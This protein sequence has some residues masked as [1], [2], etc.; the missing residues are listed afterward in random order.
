MGSH[1][2]TFHPTQVSTPHLH[3][4][5]SPRPVRPVLDLPTPEGWK[6]ELTCIGLHGCNLTQVR[7][8][9]ESVLCDLRESWMRRM[10][11]VAVVQCVCDRPCLAHNAV[12]CQYDDCLHFLSLDQCLS[13]KVFVASLSPLITAET[14]Q[15]EIK[16]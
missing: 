11:Y 12:R 3:P 8:F 1:S 9:V 2:V 16:I 7:N 13:N 6:A 15:Q 14:I 5:Q 10:S 4:G